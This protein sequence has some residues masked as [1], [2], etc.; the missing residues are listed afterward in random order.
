MRGKNI[1]FFI[2]N[3]IKTYC[4]THPYS[5]SLLYSSE[6]SSFQITRTNHVYVF[7]CDG[8]PEIPKDLPNTSHDGHRRI[9]SQRCSVAQRESLCATILIEFSTKW[10]RFP[11]AATLIPCGIIGLLM[12]W[13]GGASRI[14][15]FVESP[16][17]VFRAMRF[18]VISAKLFGLQMML[19]EP[20]IYE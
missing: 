5:I 12:A 2:A 20:R 4:Q 18:N 6:F 14:Y 7:M 9:I 3:L 17:C 15:V 10:Q 1:V 13:I 11:N 19:K 8:T 16:F